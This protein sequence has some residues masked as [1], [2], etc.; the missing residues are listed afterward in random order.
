M[1]K[2]DHFVHTCKNHLMLTDDRSAT[3]R[4]DTKFFLV[5]LLS[6]LR[7][8][9]DILIRIVSGVVDRIGKC[10]CCSRW[11]I[12]FL[13][14]MLLYDLNI[15][16][17]WCKYICCILQELHQR[18]D[19]QTHVGRLQDCYLLRAKRYLVELLRGKSGRTKY[20]WNLLINCIIKQ[21]INRNGCCK[22]NNHICLDIT[23]VD[24]CK[25]RISVFSIIYD[26]NAGND[27]HIR[28]FLAKSCDDLPHL[29]VTT[30]HNHTNHL[31]FLPV[32]LSVL[33]D[34]YTKSCHCFL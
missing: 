21:L 23:C 10:Q 22:I 2:L 29:T 3:Y 30:M 17:S 5:T 7:T 28:I 33:L 9:I 6:Y 12:H 1:L 26:I 19:T 27:L 34:F 11:C 18:I 20:N 8:V 31:F 4:R 32:C 14:M 16:T 13:I 15:I 25:Y 24:I